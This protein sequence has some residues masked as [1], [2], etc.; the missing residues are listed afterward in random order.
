MK[1]LLSSE[2]EVK[3][4][5]TKLQLSISRTLIFLTKRFV[6]VLLLK[7]RFEP[8]KCT[9]HPLKLRDPVVFSIFTEMCDP[10]HNR[11]ENVFI[12][13]KRDSCIFHVSILCA[14]LCQCSEGRSGPQAP[15][16]SAIPSLTRSTHDTL[17]EQ[18]FLRITF[19]FC[20]LR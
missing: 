16:L 3:R 12:T 11:F 19:F 5:N 6:H 17:F 18:R 1:S 4:L 13:P 20:F 9:V 8:P 14:A 15:T 2:D 10:L 7:L